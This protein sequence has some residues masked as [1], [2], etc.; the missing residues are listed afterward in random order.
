MDFSFSEEQ[1]MLRKVARNFCAN[2]CPTNLVREM[3]KDQQG[4]PTDLWNK[5]AGLGWIGLAFPEE[6]G[7][8][9]GSFLDLAVL[10]DEMGRARLPGPF[11]STVVLGGFI[12]LEAGNEAQKNDLLPNIANGDL[13]V[14]L[15]LTEHS[16]SFNAAGVELS[17]IAD[18]EDFI[19]DGTK[20]FVPDAHVA[21]YIVCVARTDDGADKEKGVTLFLVDA[22]KSG[23][24]CNPLE[25]IAGDKQC[26]VIFNK[27]RIPRENIIG[28]VDQG[29]TYVKNLLQK[30]TSAKCVEITGGAQQILDMTLAYAKERV[31]FGH[32]IRT[33]QAIQHH[34]TNMAT[35][36]EGSMFIAYQA[37][38]MVSEALP[39]SKEV[40]MAK[41][42]VGDA[43]RRITLLGHQVHGAIGFTEDHDLT[44]Y[45]RRSRAWETAFGDSYFQ[46]EIIAQQLG[47]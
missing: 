28:E 24:S 27:V 37:A 5:M 33:L 38:W 4:Y 11:F 25:T 30:A 21:D 20:F 26:E 32:P 22:K 2:E 16:A 19:L 13:I 7:G 3:E 18:K 15:A 44:L 41:A 31:Q 17:A 14:T 9:G 43:F 23:V 1:D 29:W 35:D 8:T 12:I 40:A 10:L 39:C 47:L 34:C 42:W 46:R 36:V 45:S 6:Y